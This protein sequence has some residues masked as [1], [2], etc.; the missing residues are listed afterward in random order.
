[1]FRIS[2]GILFQS[3][4]AMLEKALSPYVFVRDLGPF[5]SLFETE[6]NDLEYWLHCR[7][8][9]LATLQNTSGIGCIAEYPGT[10]SYLRVAGYGEWL[11][12]A[13]Y[14]NW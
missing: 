2:F 4:G 12:V 1:M 7:I 6:R 8:A 11:R 3:F 13:T 9:E 5:N 10:F 14:L